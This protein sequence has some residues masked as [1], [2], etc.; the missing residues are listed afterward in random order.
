M[1]DN[2]FALLLIFV[3]SFVPANIIYL[4]IKNYKEDCT[5]IAAY[6]EKNK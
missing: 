5:V 6:K 3:A 2:D 4:A 1:T